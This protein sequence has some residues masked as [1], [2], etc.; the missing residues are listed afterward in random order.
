MAVGDRTLTAF[1]PPVY[2]NPS[3]TGFYD[4]KSKGL[5]SSDCFGAIL[6]RSTQNAAD[7]TEQE[8]REGHV[9]WTTVDSP[10]VHKVD[11]G[12]FAAELKKVEQ[13]E[14][15]LL[16]SSHLPMARGDMLHALCVET[17][18]AIDATPFTGPNQAA[19]EEMLKQM[20]DAPPH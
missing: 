6:Q 18:A 5:F 2:D 1:R 10:W 19:L 15:E 8:L 3:T 12:A 4:S 17:A 13:F 20:T 9:F 16:F 7:L 11:K 14:P